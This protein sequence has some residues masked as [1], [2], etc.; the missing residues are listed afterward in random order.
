MT[1]AQSYA[2]VA[3][4]KAY[5]TLRGLDLP[6]DDVAVEKL[7]ILAMDFVESFRADF[8]GS[9]VTAEQSLQFPRTGV[10]LD[11]FTLDSAVIPKCLKDAVAQLACDANTAELMPVG[12]GR[13]VLREKVDVIETQY[14]QSGVTNVQPVFTKAEALLEP[15]LIRGVWGTLSSLRV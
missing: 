6:A 15:L 9:K 7:I 8:Q 4:V 1:D 3:E 10:Q 2:S 5:A 13:E 11:G 12:D 14:A